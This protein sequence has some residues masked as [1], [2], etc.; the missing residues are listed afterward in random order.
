M[1]RKPELIVAVVLF[2]LLVLPSIAS[3]ADAISTHAVGDYLTGEVSYVFQVVM[4]LVFLVGL[5]M[6]GI[7][8][9]SHNPDTRS[10]GY[11]AVAA[12]VIV[13]LLYYLVPGILSE[14]GSKSTSTAVFS[15][16]GNNTSTSGGW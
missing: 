5:A 14:L 1:N 15:F 3:A 9:F 7:G 6:V 8:A 2:A 13:A 11:L 4:I 10:R 12:V 16:G